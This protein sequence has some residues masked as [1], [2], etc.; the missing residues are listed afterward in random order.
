MAAQDGHDADALSAHLKHL[1]VSKEDKK[2]EAIVA[3]EFS[4]ELSNLFDEVDEVYCDCE[5]VDLS[6]EGSVCIVQI[7]TSEQTVIVDVLGK[8]HND[9]LIQWLRVILESDKVK[10]I[11][12]DCRMDS[13]ALW[14]LL[15]VS[16]S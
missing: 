16:L 14:H 5:G 3:S 10:K 13:D 8:K 15:Q 1:H 4:N 6:R 7:A 11:I 9:P 12:H 2:T